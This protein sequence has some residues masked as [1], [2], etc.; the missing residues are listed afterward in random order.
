M[1]DWL[2]TNVV[3]IEWWHNKLA[4]EP[5]ALHLYRVHCHATQTWAQYSSSFPFSLLLLQV[6]LPNLIITTWLGWH[7]CY[8]YLLFIADMCNKLGEKRTWCREDCNFLSFR[9]WSSTGVD[10]GGNKSLEPIIIGHHFLSANWV[11]YF[12]FRALL[13]EQTIWAWTELWKGHLFM[14]LCVKWWWWWS[15]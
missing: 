13:A 11:Q 9:L 7:D 5:G 15:S 10:G 1:L 6:T 3:A 14:F 12:W 2:R 4:P 8:R